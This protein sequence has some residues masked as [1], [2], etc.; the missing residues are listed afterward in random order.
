MRQVAVG[1]NFQKLP[2]DAARRNPFVRPVCK[3]FRAVWSCEK[4]ILGLFRPVWSGESGQGGAAG[5]S[6]GAE[7]RA[8]LRQRGHTG[9]RLEAGGQ[10]S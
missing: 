4:E 8:L 2:I 9:G 10:R 7:S 3:R 1:S 5:L 6:T